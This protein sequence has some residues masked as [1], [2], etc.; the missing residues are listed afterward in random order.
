MAVRPDDC[1]SEGA[2][3]IYWTF[4]TY[5]KYLSDYINDG[6]QKAIDRAGAFFCFSTAQFNQQKVDGVQ[7]VS[8]FGGMVCP[9]EKAGEL[10]RE[11]DRVYHAGVKQ[12]IAENGI[13]AIIK[14]ELLNHECYYTGDIED[15][16]EKLKDY[17]VGYDE[18]LAVYRRE[19]DTVEV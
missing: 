11:L 16:V 1:E 15:A 13:D 3:I 18:I 6:Q 14:R 12:D 17:G 5:M 2:T 19:R 8:L 7:Y 4:W 10:V 9:K